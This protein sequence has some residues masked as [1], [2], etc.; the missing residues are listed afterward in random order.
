MKNRKVKKAVQKFM[1]YYFGIT[2][3][4]DAIMQMN[5]KRPRLTRGDMIILNTPV[6]KRDIEE[7]RK[8]RQEGFRQAC[9]ETLG[10]DPN[11][12]Y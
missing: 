3:N 2:G 4:D 11:D 6:I 1:R 12:N 10:E 8:Y 5:K 7:I 9:I